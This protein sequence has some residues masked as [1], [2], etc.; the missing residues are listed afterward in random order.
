[1]TSYLFNFGY[2]IHERINYLE[3]AILAPLFWNQSYIVLVLNSQI[4]VD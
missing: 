3:K 2:N 4:A 1:M